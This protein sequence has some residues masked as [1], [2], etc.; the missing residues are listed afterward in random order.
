MS[1]T[2]DLLEANRSYAETFP[3]GNL[4]TEPA[5]RL[6]VVC[7]MDSR[8]DVF[9]ATGLRLGDAH[10]LRNA[11]GIV[12]EDV[13]RSLVISQHLLGTRSIAVVHHT[14]CGAQRFTDADLSAAIHERTGYTPPF[15]LGAFVDLDES[16]RE[17]LRK[18]RGSAYLVETTDIRGFV[19]DVDTGRLRE[20]E[21]D[22]A[23]A[24]AS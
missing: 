15:A 23:P 7:C 18:L 22:D 8:I 14:K 17:S 1:A 4:A 13:L 20:V 3:Y 16:V 21:A 5:R 2:D 24:P 6:V 12:T 11:G 9:D 10:I 19:Y